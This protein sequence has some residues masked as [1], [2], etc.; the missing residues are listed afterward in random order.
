MQFI[1]TAMVFIRSGKGGTGCVSFHREKFVQK[2]GPDGGDGGSVIFIAD[3][4]ANTLSN[5][6]H[7]PRLYGGNGQYG[8]GRN[9]S[10]KKGKDVKCRVPCGTV[11]K[12][13]ETG[14]IICEV[15]D[16]DKPVIISAGGSGGRGNQHFAS[17]TNQSPTHFEPGQPSVEFKSYLELKLMADVGLVGLPNAGKSSLITALSNAAPKVADYPFTTLTPNLGVINVRD[18]RSIVMA[19]IPGIIEG[20][21]KG[22]GL[23]LK[24]LKHIERTRVLVILLDISSYAETP[25]REAL[26]I[27]LH[28]LDNFGEG[29]SEKERIVVA[30]KIDLDP[31]GEALADIQEAIPQGMKLFAI[32]AATRSGLGELLQE[33]DRMVYGAVPTS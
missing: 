10:G 1:D 12:D 7:S 33:L 19:D 15:L 9:R 6:K 2:G 31:D 20:A 21:S 28:E 22:K 4:N 17:A 11:V 25:A 23:G 13:N 26:R 27:L 30:N 18:F 24:F 3:P 5:F 32:S 16:P 14:Q 29:L 8:M